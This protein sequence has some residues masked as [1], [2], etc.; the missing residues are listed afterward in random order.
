MDEGNTLKLQYGLDEVLWLFSLSHENMRIILRVHHLTMISSALL[1]KN[2]Y[3][4]KEFLSLLSSWIELFYC[5]IWSF[6]VSWWSFLPC[7]WVHEHGQWTLSSYSI[8]TLQIVGD[9]ISQQQLKKYN[10]ACY[11]YYEE[12]FHDMKGS[13]VIL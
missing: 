9:F 12:L 7:H 8:E 11:F 10:V 4:N 5:L 6:M 1:W 2:F 13:M 3:Q